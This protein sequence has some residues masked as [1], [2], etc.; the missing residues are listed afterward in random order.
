MAEAELRQR[1]QQGGSEVDVDTD[2]T[3]DIK[4]TD[5]D[6]SRDA[7]KHR[8]HNHDHKQVISRVSSVCSQQPYSTLHHGDPR[9]FCFYSLQPVV[10]AILM[11]LPG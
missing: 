9:T 1:R 2:K 11:S 6:E 3:K 8:N 7:R 4:Q 10:F 5:R